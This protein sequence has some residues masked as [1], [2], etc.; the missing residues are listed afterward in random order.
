MRLNLTINISIW[1][2]T[3]L[4]KEKHKLGTFPTFNRCKENLKVEVKEIETKDIDDIPIN[5]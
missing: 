5:R 2:R 1:N 3:I 4:R